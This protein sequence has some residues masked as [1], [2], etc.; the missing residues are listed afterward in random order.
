VFLVNSRLGLVCAT[1]SSSGREGRHPTK[2]ILL[3][4]LRMQF[5]EFLNQGSLD[6]LRILYVPTCVGL[7]YGHL[8]HSLEAF[9]G[10]MGSLASPRTA[11]HR[12]SGLMT[13]RICLEDPPTH[14]PQGNQRLGRATLLRPPFAALVPGWSVAP[15][16]SL[17]ALDSGLARMRWYWNINQSSI[18]YVCRPRLRSRL[19]L[20]G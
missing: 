17:S 16:G 1:R 7:G 6:R 2:V 20:G 9:L 19:T 3:P 4:K 5:A 15:K 14:L 10:S 13:L 18:A 11:R 12:V 8:V